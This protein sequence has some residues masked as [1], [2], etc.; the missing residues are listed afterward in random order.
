MTHHGYKHEG[1]KEKNYA[2][3]STRETSEN[4]EGVLFYVS[5]KLRVA[6]CSDHAQFLIQHCVGT[7]HGVARFEAFS[8][9]TDIIVLR[10]LLHTR[11]GVPMGQVMQLTSGMPRK[12]RNSTTQLK[13][14]TQRMLVSGIGAS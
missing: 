2:A 9:P 11:Y 7:R 6:V 12:A 14:Y 8:Y 10:R 5:P 1:L 13:K 4:Y 3:Y